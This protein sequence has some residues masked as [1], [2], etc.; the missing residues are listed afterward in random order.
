MAAFQ[1]IAFI[2]AT[3]MNLRGV[4][5]GLLVFNSIFTSKNKRKF[6]QLI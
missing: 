1:P 2:L 5:S 6:K 4:P 3:S